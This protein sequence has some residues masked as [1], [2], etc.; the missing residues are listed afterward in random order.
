M[1]ATNSLVGLHLLTALFFT[2]AT[3]W[4]SSTLANDLVFSASA[5]AN[6][7]VWTLL[8]Y[9]FVHAI[10]LWFAVGLFFFWRFAGEIENLLGTRKFVRFYLAI[11]AFPPLGLFLLSPFIGDLSL[12]GEGSVHFAVFVGFS[13]IYPNAAMWFNIPVKWFV[14]LIVSVQTLQYLGYKSWGSLAALWFSILAAF[15]LLHREGVTS[16]HRITTWLKARSPLGSPPQR[17]A[18]S[19]SSK[20]KAPVVPTIAREPRIDAILD[21]ISAQGFQSLTPEEKAILSETSAKYNNRKQ[22]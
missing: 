16:C 21:K 15:I 19:S 12:A 1:D 13:L 3:G 9:P 10:D 20:L 2:F 8:T 11:T 22:P 4:F 17:P 5:L 18:R 6:L 7:R 14:L